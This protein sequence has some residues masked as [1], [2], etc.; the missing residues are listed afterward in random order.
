MFEVLTAKTGCILLGESQSSKSTLIDTLSG[1]LNY[2]SYN[3]LKL[4][5]A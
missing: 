5:I 1:A 2:A 4:R 3:E